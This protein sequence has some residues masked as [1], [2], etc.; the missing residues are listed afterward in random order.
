MLLAAIT[1]SATPYKGKLVS[2]HANT[3]NV[4]GPNLLQR[5]PGNRTVPG[6][7][8]IPQNGPGAPHLGQFSSVHACLDECLRRFP[9]SCYSATHYAGADC[10]AVTTQYFDWFPALDTLGTKNVT[11][12]RVWYGCLTDD[13]CARNGVCGRGG[14]CAC[15]SGWVGPACTQLDLQ[16]TLNGQEAGYNYVI[17][18]Q[19]VS[20]WGG[21][22][23]QDESGLYHLWV[24][25]FTKHCGII[26]WGENSIILHTTSTT[27]LGPYR[28]ANGT[29]EAS[30]VFPIFSHEPDVKRGP[31]GEWIM[32][33]SRHVPNSGRPEC[34]CKD[35]VTPDS[36][37]DYATPDTNP[38]AMSWSMS[39]WGPWSEPVTVIED[40]QSDSNLSPLIRADGSLIGLWR[41]F[42]DSP[43]WGHPGWKV[44]A[45]HT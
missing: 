40:T 7:F 30:T 25:H 17:D 15:A 4:L 3:D 26:A 20:S 36:C 39:P 12:A 9:Y 21:V 28:P 42:N 6:G 13:D 45:I 37:T 14:V 44:S 8:V 23:L 27:L 32:F 31:H 33:H 1:T 18:G 2:I 35:G 22:P 41:S 24:S 5:L 34:E 38:T 19:N 43:A 10:Y 11:T 16:P 29:V